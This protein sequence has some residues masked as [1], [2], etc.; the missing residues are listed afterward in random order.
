MV[1]KDNFSINHLFFSK[2]IIIAVDGESFTLKLKT[3]K[4]YYTDSD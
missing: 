1:I 2:D 4:D 3:L